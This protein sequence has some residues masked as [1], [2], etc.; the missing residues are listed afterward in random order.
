MLLGC[1]RESS[2][3]SITHRILKGLSLFALLSFV[4]GFRLPPLY[5]A[6]STPHIG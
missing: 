3:F 4:F 2:C 6:L 5:L 1:S